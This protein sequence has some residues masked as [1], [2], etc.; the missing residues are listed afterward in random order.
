ME[1]DIRSAL[2]ASA[3][4]APL[5]AT[6]GRGRRRRRCRA[7]LR[8][9]LAGEA[10]APRAVDQIARELIAHISPIVSAFDPAVVVIGGHLVRAGDLAV[11]PTQRRLVQACAVPPEVRVSQLGE[12]AMTLGDIR[13]APTRSKRVSSASRTSCERRAAVTAIALRRTRL[14][15]RWRGRTPTRRPAALSRAHARPAVPPGDGGPDS[16]RR[17]THR[18]SSNLSTC[19]GGCSGASLPHDGGTSFD[20]GPRSITRLLSDAPRAKFRRRRPDIPAECCAEVLARCEAERVRDHRDR[21]IAIEQ[22][23]S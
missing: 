5:T 10:S 21:L 20:G 8:R 19:T 7:D 12:E 4:A 9:R 14:M 15:G 16:N 11:E 2:R 23:P 3:R 6:N 18:R 1:Q 13:A 22:R 17:A